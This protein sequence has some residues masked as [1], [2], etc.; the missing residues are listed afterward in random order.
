MRPYIARG[1]G[2]YDAYLGIEELLFFD[3]FHEGVDV[4]A[5]GLR[6]AGRIDGQ[7]VWMI[8]VYDVVH[9]LLEV[10][11]ASEDH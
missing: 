7:N 5:Y 1:I 3:L 2:N 6:G 10:V 11:S 8:D 9:R 4:V